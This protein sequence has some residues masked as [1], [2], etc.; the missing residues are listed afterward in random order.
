M[1]IAVF[2]LFQRSFPKCFFE[3]GSHKSPSVILDK[4]IG[5]GKQSF[6]IRHVKANHQLTKDQMLEVRLFCSYVALLI[7]R[8]NLLTLKFHTIMSLNLA[9]QNLVESV[10]KN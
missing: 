9:Y 6:Y 2:N 4:K 10:S 8:K 5:L 7:W 1:E 3:A